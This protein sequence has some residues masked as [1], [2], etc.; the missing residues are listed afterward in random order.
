MKEDTHGPARQ[1]DL[2]QV[3]PL[4]RRSKVGGL[5]T[6]KFLAHI[7]AYFRP[8]LPIIYTMTVPSRT[9]PPW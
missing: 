6:I 8:A 9:H 2:S 5:L 1:V 7:S 4:L 3:G